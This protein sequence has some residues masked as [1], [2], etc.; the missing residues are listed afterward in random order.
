MAAHD[1]PLNQCG[2]TPR[3][4]TLPTIAIGV[5]LTAVALCVHI[6]S[7]WDGTV[8]DDYAHQKGLREHGWSYDEL[9]QTLVI[10][11]ADWLHTWWQDQPVRWE[12]GRPFFIL[13]MKF[14][15]RVLGGDD[16]AA[17]H[18]F[19]I[20]AHVLSTWMLAWLAW[21]VTGSGGW[22]LL[23]GVLFALYPHAVVTV[24]WPSS[25]NVVTS[26]TLLLA[27]LLCYWRA[28]S[29]GFLCEFDGSA[30]VRPLRMASTIGML[31]FWILA[32]LTRENSLL[33]PPVLVALEWSLGGWRRVWARRNVFI[34]FA[35]FGVLFIVW[36]VAAVPHGLPPVYSRRPGDDLV[37]Y[38][39]WCV[40]KLL[41]YV[42]A[43]IWVAPMTIGPT[44]R[45]NPWTEVPGDCL[46]MLGIVA[47]IGGGYLL[48]TRSVRGAWLWPLWIILAVLPVVPVVAAP[49]SG[50]LSGVGFALGAA[51]VGAQ[52]VR[53][54]SG[55]ARHTWRSLL[56]FYV[57]ACALFSMWNRWIWTGAIAA[58]RYALAWIEADPPPPATD[59]VFFINMPFVNVYN[60]LS[61]IERLDSEF[62][63][64]NCHILSWA[65]DAFVISEPVVVEKADEYS[66]S[67]STDG[68]PFF[69]RLLGRFLIEAFRAEGPFNT[70]DVIAGESFDVRIDEVDDDGVHKLTFTFPRRLDDPSYCFYVSTADC[71]ATR[72]RFNAGNSG[73][74]EVTDYANIDRRILREYTSAVPIDKR[75]HDNLLAITRALA[76]DLASNLQPL[77]AQDE[78]TAEE[79]KRVSEWWRRDVDAALL[80]LH[81]DRRQ[82]FAQFI[83]EREEVPHSRMWAGKVVRS[84]LYLT[85]P[86]FPGPRR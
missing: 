42:C 45:Y 69:S 37:E 64:V 71:G 34:A 27:A 53:T 61:L 82:E 58:E 60:K 41:H 67:L 84:D 3:F 24:A 38:G 68:Q 59:D 30:T 16:P 18:A 31:V 73:I 11:P 76:G 9:M 26:T 49:H 23:A 63:N 54:R 5:L 25:Q 14:V 83:K 15:Y 21:R 40:A 2:T 46:L 48:F 47:V 10:E 7:L 22:A 86:P 4:R 66:F 6:W 13:S 52:T 29:V 33:L 79:W 56:G 55:F 62:E 35:V 20:I 57:V 75:D 17:L 19:S 1:S 77:L 72:L 74:D 44:G 85:G 51:I 32:L 78:L 8:L 36:R 81:W 12:Y 43:S 70:G 28:A 39:L 80:E 50:Y 65:P